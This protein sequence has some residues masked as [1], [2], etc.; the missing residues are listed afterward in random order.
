MITRSFILGIA[1]T[2]TS[3]QLCAQSG[4]PTET[5]EVE[6]N[7]LEIQIFGGYSSL[8]LTDAKESFEKSIVG[9]RAL[10]VNIERQTFFPENM[11]VGGTIGFSLNDSQELGLGGYW[12]STGAVS[13]YRDWAGTFEMRMDVKVLAAFVYC[14]G[15]L[16][17]LGQIK[18]YVCVRPGVVWGSTKYRQSLALV[19]LG[20][21]TSDEETVSGFGFL[22]ELTL[23][24]KAPVAGPVA[25]SLHGGYRYAEIPETG[26]SGGSHGPPMQLSGWVIILGIGVSL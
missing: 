2:G 4:T 21:S 22:A 25:A 8:Q 17:S 15:D 1:L 9:Y 16:F 12:M 14:R 11:L 5:K 10:G 7:Q 24:L 20:G 23:G 6:A 18:G 19:L 26:G 3:W 13:R